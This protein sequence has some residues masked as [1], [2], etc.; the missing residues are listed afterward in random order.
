VW[1]LPYLDAALIGKGCQRLFLV[2]FVMP[3]MRR[4]QRVDLA[5]DLAGDV[6]FQLLDVL[7]LL[8]DD[9]FDQVADGQH[10]DDAAG[11]DHR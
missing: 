7:G 3:H 1:G 10:A 11:F 8:L 4:G 2:H 6:A 9:G 5:G